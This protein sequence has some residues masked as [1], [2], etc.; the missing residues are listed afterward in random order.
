MAEPGVAR[1]PPAATPAEVGEYAAAELAGFLAT[2]VNPGAPQREE[3]REVVPRAAFTAAARIGLL[4]YLLPRDVGGLG[5][6]RRVF[7]LLLEQLGSLC[8]DMAFPF[9]LSMYA[10]IPTVVL[11]AGRPGLVERYVRPMAAG[12]VLGTF[13]FTDFGDAFEFQTRAVRKGDQWVVS[14]VKC[15]QTGGALA[16]VF[17]TY[18][19]DESDDLRV[20]LVDREDPGVSTVPVTTMGIRS[21]GL[22]QL[23]L[24]E[25]VLPAD[26]DLSGPDGLADAQMFLNSRRLFQVCPL[27]GAMRR[28]IEVS[29]RH[30]DGV[31]REGRPLTQAQAVQGRLGTMYAKYLTS[32]VVLHDALDRMGRGDVNAVYDPVISAAKYV[33]TENAVDVGERAIRLTG[34]RGYSTVLPLERMFRAVLASVTG[35]TAQDILEINLGVIAMSRITLA[36]R[37]RRAW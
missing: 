7:G 29:V 36:D 33:V 35:Q 9:M 16:D 5:G 2:E 19:R 17:V 12:D 26:R 22:T 24:D 21:G 13:A 25:V 30:L 8:D 31:I 37:S 34:W 32:Q 4:N 15:L 28:M 11:A 1:L 27:V 23:T 10:D 14:G 20:L 3:D 6:S 18:A